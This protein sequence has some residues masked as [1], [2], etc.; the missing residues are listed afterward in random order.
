MKLQY[1]IIF[2]QPKFPQVNRTLVADKLKMLYIYIYTTPSCS[3]LR[4]LQMYYKKIKLQNC[5]L[6]KQIIPPVPAP[7]PG[8]FSRPFL[9]AMDG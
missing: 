3:F 7:Q 9:Q 4:Y 5:F 6:L 1:F 2:Y 8:V